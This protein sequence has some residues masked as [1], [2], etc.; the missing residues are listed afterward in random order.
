MRGEDAVQTTADGKVSGSPPHARGRLAH[1]VF[2]SAPALDHPRM[3]GEDGNVATAETYGL[4]S[5]PH[6]RGRPGIANRQGQAH[7]ITPAC[8]GKTRILGP[9]SM[10]GGDHPRMRG[11]DLRVV[12]GHVYIKGITPACA[13]KTLKLFPEKITLTDHPRMRGEDE[14]GETYHG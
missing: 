8:A 7:R 2:L 6:A 10:K 11:E 12:V 4:G 5:P 3:R 9:G 1:C 13:G 14:K